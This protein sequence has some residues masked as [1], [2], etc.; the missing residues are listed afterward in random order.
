MYPGHIVERTDK[1]TLFKRPLHP[2]TEQLLLVGLPFP[3][4]LSPGG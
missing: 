2:W 4:A 1:R 3:L